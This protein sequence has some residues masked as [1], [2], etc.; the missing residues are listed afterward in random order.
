VID[1]LE[2]RSGSVQRRRLPDVRP[3]AMH[4]VDCMYSFQLP[5]F[6]TYGIIL[7]EFVSFAVRQGNHSQPE[8]F[9]TTVASDDDQ[10]VNSCSSRRSNAR[11][12]SR[13]P[14]LRLF[15]NNSTNEYLR[16]SSQNQSSSHTAT[17]CENIADSSGK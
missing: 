3:E 4:D 1:D 2:E 6:V 11:R 17:V 12:T 7:K 13:S 8:K 14:I 15:T 9:F 5:L 16:R 10:D